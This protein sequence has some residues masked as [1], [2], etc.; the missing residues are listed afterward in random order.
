MEESARMVDLVNLKE[1][2]ENNMEHMD[3][4]MRKGLDI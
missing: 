1:M 3:N 2:L 4:K